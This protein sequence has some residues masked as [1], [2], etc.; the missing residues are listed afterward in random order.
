MESFLA[1]C[2]GQT[3]LLSG[4][5]GGFDI[6]GCILLYERIKAVAAKV[7]L[8]NLSFTQDEVL[9]TSGAAQFGRYLWKVN[10]DTV[11][12]VD[13]YPEA[14][15]ARALGTPVYALSPLCKI[16]DIT[17]AYQT[18]FD[19][20]GGVVGVHV[21]IDGGCD[22]LLRGTEV[23]LATPVEDMM[24]LRAVIDFP[25]PYQY[26]MCIGANVDLGHGVIQRDLDQR[27]SDLRASGIMLAEEGPL[28]IKVHPHAKQYH[29]IVMNS[30]PM[31]TIVQSLAS[32]G[33]EGHRGLY[34]PP[35]L[36]PR[37][38]ANKVPITDQT[39]TLFLFDMKGVAREVNYLRLLHP[40]MG[41]NGFQQVLRTYRSSV[42][43]R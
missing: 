1:S 43:Q 39:C 31:L 28:D 23:G 12:I 40:S 10:P 2:A 26:I 4:C 32:A 6:F 29:Q 3:V 9:K 15:L 16:Q 30:K 13:Y 17:E 42:G 5:G 19:A 20:E 35:H 18:L 22:V 33:M 14:H 41:Q 34:T 7:I 11:P 8:L 36:V 24:H 37:I 21:L 38:K 25:V 27:L